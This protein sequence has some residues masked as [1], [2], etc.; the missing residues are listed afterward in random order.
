VQKF[1]NYRLPLAIVGDITVRA[2]AGSA[3]ESF[4]RESNRGRQLWF[5]PTLADFE[6]KLTARSG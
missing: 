4:V 2:A 6:A 5:T 1:V 3:F